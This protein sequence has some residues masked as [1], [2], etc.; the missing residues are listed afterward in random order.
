LDVT[1]NEADLGKPIGSDAENEKS[2]YVTL[3]GIE[4]AEKLAEEYTKK[5]IESLQMFEENGELVALA[6][7]LMGRK[8]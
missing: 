5:A 6:N 3:F 1:G 2:T 7:K 4:E 8:A